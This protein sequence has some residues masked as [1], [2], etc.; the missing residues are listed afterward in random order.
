MDIHTQRT[1]IA[2]CVVVLIGISVGCSS[3]QTTPESA[4]RPMGVFEYVAQSNDLRGTITIRSD[5][6]LIDPDVGYCEPARQ[7]NFEA[8]QYRCTGHKYE[9]VHIWLDRRNPLRSSRWSG[10]VTVQRQRQVC[11]QEGRN[12]QG[13]RVCLRYGTESYETVSTVGGHLVLRPAP[14]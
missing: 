1:R 9:P 5:T 2:G 4:A 8:V 6:M 3:R 10:R 14:S 11:V 13:Q 12:Q 7:P